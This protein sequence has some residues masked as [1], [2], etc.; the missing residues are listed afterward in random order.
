MAWTGQDPSLTLS[1]YSQ[2]YGY[3]PNIGLT[4][5]DLLDL[6]TNIDPWDNI[7]FAMLP[8]RRARSTTHE[9]PTDVLP[10]VARSGVPDGA[11]FEAQAITRPYR[12]QN[13]TQIFRWDVSVT[14]SE[15]EMETAG[16]GDK[17]A[18]QI[19]NG[20]HALAKAVEQRITDIGTGAPTIGTR[21]LDNQGQLTGYA[22]LAGNAGATAVPGYGGTAFFGAMGV[23]APGRRMAPLMQLIAQ[24]G[25]AGSPIQTG[26]W[27]V[28][29]VDGGGVTLTA[30]KVDDICEIMFGNGLTPETLVL[31]HGSKR[32]LA[33]DLLVTSAGA[34]TINT[35][36]IQA[37]ERKV[38]RGVDVYEGDLASLSVIPN[39]SIAVPSGT[40]GYGAAWVLQKD[41]L[42]IA[43]YR[44]IK[45][46][47]ISKRGDS[48][49][50]MLITELTLELLH[51]VGAG[52]V[53]RI[54]S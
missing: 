48:D 45:A 28:P 19:L 50:K 41:K 27:K 4:K 38:I 54:I 37:T 43:F 49:D 40:D 7:V 35:R 46:V 21:A 33:G 34:S 36:F 18:Y 1:V 15:A 6:I 23:S 8:K 16:I 51:P 32:D 10:T 31:N 3:G 11:A 53:V 29:L 20:T 9:W 22:N 52:A 5:E 17:L 30:A 12:L 44:P 47:P 13:Y 24:T 39:R 26:A 25:A 14:G 2:G 42:G